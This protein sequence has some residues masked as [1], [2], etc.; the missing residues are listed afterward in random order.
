MEASTPR[1]M[2]ARSGI[3]YGWC[4]ALVS[5]F[6]L[7]LGPVPVLVFS[8]GVFI[9]PA[10]TEFHSGRGAISLAL[11]LHNAVTALGLP[12]MGGLVDRIGARKVVLASLITSGGLLL[13]SYVWS[14]RLWQFYLI[15]SLAGLF[16]GGAGPVPLGKVIS[17]WF[18]KYRGLALGIMSSGVGA[19][20]I[21]MPALAQHLITKYGWHFAY[22]AIGAAILVITVPV[23]GTVLKDA[24]EQLGLLPDGV[25]CIPG[26]PSH[27]YDRPGVNLR[28]ALGTRAFWLLLL[29]AALIAGS[30]HACFGHLPAILTDRGSS[31]HAAAL[32]S[33]LFGAGTLFGRALPGYLLD[34]CFAPFIGA[35]LFC[36]AAAG[37]VLLLAAQ[38]PQAAFAA[39]FVIGIGWGSEADIKPFL[40]SRYFGL[41]SFGA[42]Y[43]LIFAGFV[44]AGGLGVY[45][46]GVAFDATHSY[47]WG[48]RIALIGV[49]FS[50]VLLILLGPY[51]YKQR[52]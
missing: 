23:I 7:L 42:I 43:A 1:E 3:F 18:D 35:L 6:G 21:V 9:K 14:G 38:S 19:G 11:T 34:R 36:C 48:L 12:F 29:A 31:A 40:V 4:V 33:S 25:R 20:A 32:A 27:A 47:V 28:E 50:A 2:K 17:R 30:I 8:F 22:A 26:P 51:R 39:A 15:F 5:A 41:R 45:L 46:M 52:L 10:A 24:P 13:S 16:S 44:L 37:I 49:F